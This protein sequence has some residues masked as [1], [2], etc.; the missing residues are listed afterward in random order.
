MHGARRG[1][2]RLNAVCYGAAMSGWQLSLGLLEHGVSGQVLEL[3]QAANSA[4]T[5]CTRGV[6]WRRALELSTKML[7]RRLATQVTAN[8]AISACDAG[9]Q[10]ALAQKLLEAMGTLH[11]RPDIVSYN[12]VRR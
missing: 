7:R 8:A 11:F 12:A 10:P 5:S 9:E 1:R 4:V 2:L 6:A 3:V